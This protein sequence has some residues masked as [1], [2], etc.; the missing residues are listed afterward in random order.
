MKRRRFAILLVAML[1][2]Y[3]GPAIADSSDERWT[4]GESLRQSMVRLLATASVLNVQSDFGFLETAYLGAFLRK[5]NYA[6]LTMTL[7]EGTN[8]AF[9]G[10]GN[11]PTRDL[12]I[13]VLDESD[14]VIAS[15]VKRDSTPIVKFTPPR[16]GRYR[17]RLM[18]QDADAA[19]FCG[20]VLMRQEGWDV[21]TRNLDVALSN[22]LK[23][24]VSVAKQ[25]P[26]RFLSVPGEWAVIGSIL[27]PGESHTL[28]DVH[29]GEGRRVIV[30]AGDTVCTDI[31]LS[32]FLDA[33]PFEVLNKDEDKDALPLVQCKATDANRY[34][35]IVRNAK[36]KGGA[37]ILTA[38]LDIE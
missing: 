37:M 16:T 29:L 23:A 18:L 24:C 10:S 27:K 25:K 17:I 35:I 3:V 31:D 19:C 38:I 9:L 5:G 36:S 28:S 6:F 4:P 22:M 7:E 33:M 34:G 1:P 15:D 11:E 20:I 30:A 13:V 2:L 12:D 26:A 8:Y 21:P 14:K 32:V